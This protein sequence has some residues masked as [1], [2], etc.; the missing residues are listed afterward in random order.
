MA[1]L[2]PTSCTQQSSRSSRYWFVNCGSFEPTVVPGSCRS[3]Q[4]RLPL[5]LETWNRLALQSG[6]VCVSFSSLE[7]R[8]AALACAP[9]RVAEPIWLSQLA[10]RQCLPTGESRET[11]SGRCVAAGDDHCN[12]FL[13]ICMVDDRL[14]G[15]PSSLLRSI[16]S[17]RQRSKTAHR[18]GV[19]GGE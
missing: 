10:A 3:C 17:K 7:S 15:L 14:R 8:I 16:W 18:R 11:V 5:L 19:Y 1:N 2:C 6:P 12:N 4:I 9:R 13:K